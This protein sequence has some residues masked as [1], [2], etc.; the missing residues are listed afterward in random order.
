MTILFFLSK[1]HH[2]YF[3]VNNV[4]FKY[5]QAPSSKNHEK[6]GKNRNFSDF[7]MEKSRK[8]LKK[9]QFYPCFL[10]H[11]RKFA[12]R[13]RIFLRRKTNNDLTAILT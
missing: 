13:L 7:S 3:S 10:P 4:F 6:T 9:S 2:H 1:N 11:L 12:N 8:T 5:A